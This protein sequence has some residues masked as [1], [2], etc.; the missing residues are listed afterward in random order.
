MLMIEPRGLAMLG[1]RFVIQVS[2][3]QCPEATHPQP[4]TTLPSKPDPIVD[5]DKEEG[6]KMFL[7]H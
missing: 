7:H 1:Q 6:K 5:S 2:R 4:P 3:A